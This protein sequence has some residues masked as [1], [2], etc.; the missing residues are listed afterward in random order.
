MSLALFLLFCRALLARSCGPHLLVL[1]CGRLSCLFFTLS[2]Q[3]LYGAFKRKLK[4]EIKVAQLAGYVAEHSAYHHGEQSL[5]GTIIN[6]AQTYVGANNVN[7]MEPIGQFGTRLQGGK[8]AASARY[9]FTHLAPIT[10]LLFPAADDAILNYLDD[11]GQ[12]IEPDF[13]A[14]VLPLVLI[15]GADGIGTGV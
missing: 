6:M 12:K 10:R 14:P 13:Y 5:C 3:V 11:D 7:L 4:D 8:D 1:Y 9:I 15:N 2:A